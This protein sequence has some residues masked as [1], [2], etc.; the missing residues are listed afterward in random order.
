V[1]LECVPNVSLGPQ[2]DALAQVLADIE[3]AQGPGCRLLDVHA[4]RDHRRSVL[5]LAGAPAPLLGVVDELA[6]SLETHASLAGHEGVH[7][8]VGLLDVV[9]FV[10]LD[11]PRRE[12]HRVAETAMRRLAGRSV[13]TYAYAE[14]ARR[15]RTRELADVRRAFA[16]AEP[17][18]PVPLAPDQGPGRLHPRMGAACVGV[19]DPLIAYNVVL[20]TRSL[21]VGQAIA[22]AIR[23]SGGGL[24][25]VQAL[26]FGL[27]SRGDRV[28][29]STNITD[30]HATSTS[31]VLSRVRQEA[32]EHGA[33]VVDGELV[34]L[35]PREGLPKTSSQAGLGTEP[36]SLED[37][38]HEAGFSPAEVC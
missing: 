16:A 17:G 11:A 10:A 15:S 28:Q 14:L 18:H 37:A 2:D 32:E 30:A 29:V 4:D 5:T 24:P 13:P 19:R 6:A 3:A 7:P 23:A 33:G 38:L 22:R 12:A 1:L 26:A 21:E 31:D 35:A 9:P 34:G 25:G 8:R 27:A 20:D 36:V